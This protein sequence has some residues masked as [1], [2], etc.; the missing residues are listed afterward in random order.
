MTDGLQAKTHRMEQQM[1]HQRENGRL[2]RTDR[3]T[4]ERKTPDER[5]T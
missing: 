1:Q 2:R 5:Q 3:K 4:N